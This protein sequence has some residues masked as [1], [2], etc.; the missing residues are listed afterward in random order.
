[1]NFS[2]GKR[3]TLE[4]LGPPILGGALVT[5]WAWGAVVFLSLYRYE[6]PWE[7][8]GQLRLIPGFWLLYGLFAFP[9]IGVQA[10]CY[11]AI[12]EWRFS[13]GLAP[14]SWRAVALSTGLGY[15]S[16]LPLAFGY[17]YER[18][19]TWWL[20]NLLGPMVGL[21]LGLLIRRWSLR[22]ESF[23]LKGEG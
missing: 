12:M 19:D 1:M 22:P 4:L 10:A 3:I 18:R 21:V 8:V 17:G 13:R 16:G 7:A 11:A 23:P 15:L 9:M 5:L 2:R 14:R 20:F 6:H